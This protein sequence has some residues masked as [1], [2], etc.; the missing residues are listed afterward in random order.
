ME[1][2]KNFCMFFFGFI[3]SAMGSGLDTRMPLWLSWG[4]LHLL[5]FLMAP[6]CG[7]FLS[8]SPDSVLYILSWPLGHFLVV[9]AGNAYY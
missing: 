5:G 8:G 1:V 9:V 6:L 2:G 7:L 3:I 4:V